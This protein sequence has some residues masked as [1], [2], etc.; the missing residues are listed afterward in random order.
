MLTFNTEIEYEFL[1]L[2][3]ISLIAHM[4]KKKKNNDIKKPTRS[5]SRKISIFI[6]MSLICFNTAFIFRV[7]LILGTG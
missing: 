6:E 5:L 3:E 7:N 4:K 1:L 2:Y